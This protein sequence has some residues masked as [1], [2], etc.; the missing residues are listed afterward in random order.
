MGTFDA[1]NPFCHGFEEMQWHYK[2]SLQRTTLGPRKKLSE[3]VNNITGFCE[4]AGLTNNYV[5]AFILTT[6][7]DF[8]SDEVL[9]EMERA[10]KHP[11]S[12]VFVGIGPGDFSGL[13]AV[14]N[15]P[16]SVN[17]ARKN[18]SFVSVEKITR[19]VGDSS[20][21]DMFAA[22]SLEKIGIQILQQKKI[23][24][25][26]PQKENST[27]LMRLD[28]VAQERMLFNRKLMMEGQAKIARQQQLTENFKFSQ[29]TEKMDSLNS[30]IVEDKEKRMDR[31]LQQMSSILDDKESFS[32]GVEE[33]E[34]T[35]KEPEEVNNEPEQEQETEKQENEEPEQEQQENNEPE[36]QQK[37]QE[38]KEPEPQQ[39]HQE[40]N[41]PVQ[42]KQ[43][44]KEPMP[45]QEIKEPVQELQENKEPET[46]INEINKEPLSNAK[47]E[48]IVI[49]NVE[50]LDSDKMMERIESLKVGLDNTSQVEKTVLLN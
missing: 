30:A 17:Y 24:W 34:E 39:K 11:I 23:A 7:S 25:S 4:Y 48:K 46:L 26:R 40:N 33:N 13:K 8:D 1:N 2:D 16:K 12:F 28:L 18:Y 49:R 5:V 14:L 6:A 36:P 22:K 44:N 32:F 42:E 29:E 20:F 45:Q 37:Q 19:S 10:S 35:N 43:E 50:E 21:D 38:N 9:A 47:E 3:I 15:R 41:E 31:H 27:P